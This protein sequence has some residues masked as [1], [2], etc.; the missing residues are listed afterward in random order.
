V[1]NDAYANQLWLN[2]GNGVFSDEALLLGAGFNL[3]G[4]AEAG[5]GVVAADLDGDGFENSCHKTQLHAVIATELDTTDPC[6]SEHKAHCFSL[7]GCTTSLY[8]NSI[9]PGI[10]YLEPARASIK[11]GHKKNDSALVTNY[12]KLLERPPIVQVFL[13][14]G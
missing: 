10:S 4:Q 8:G 2:R 7:L 12:P 11:L 3:H 14:P 13:L 6:N 1:A 5:M 9:L